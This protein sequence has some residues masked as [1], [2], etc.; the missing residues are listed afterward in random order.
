MQ[1][2]YST[3][4]IANILRLVNI[5]HEISGRKMFEKYKVSNA[6]ELLNKTIYYN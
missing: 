4:E 2:G 6:I 1:R 5:L 3:K